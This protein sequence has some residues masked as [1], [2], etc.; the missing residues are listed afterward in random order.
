MIINFEHNGSEIGTFDINAPLH[1]I[2]EQIIV[3]A[4]PDENGFCSENPE[5]YEVLD[6]LEE[7]GYIITDCDDAQTIDLFVEDVD[8]YVNNEQLNKILSGEIK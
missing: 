4:K 2:E 7:M 1:V 6:K 8:C 5:M 3:L